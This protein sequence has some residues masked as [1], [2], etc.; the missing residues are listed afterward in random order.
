LATH[1]EGIGEKG[2]EEDIWGYEKRGN[3]RREDDIMRNFMICTPLRIIL[4]RLNRE[5]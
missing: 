5:E 3:K 1:I 4:E 2:A